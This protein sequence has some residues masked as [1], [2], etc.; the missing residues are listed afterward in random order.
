VLRVQTGGYDLCLS[1]IPQ[2][3]I[4]RNFSIQPC[5]FGKIDLPHAAAADFFQNLI[6]TNFAF[7]LSFKKFDS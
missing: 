4:E 7:S 5:I 6:M 1:Q 2:A 3:V